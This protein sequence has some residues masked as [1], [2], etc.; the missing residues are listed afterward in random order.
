MNA[1]EDTVDRPHAVWW[2]V[3]IGGLTVLAFQGF[4]DAFYGWWIAHLHALPAQ[5]V[6]MWIFVACVPIHVFEAFYCHRLARRLGLTKSAFGWGVQSF[7]L[8]YPSTRLLRRRE[9]ARKAEAHV[10]AEAR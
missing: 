3:V 4:S 1:P 7:F 8:G 6:M 2:V 10:P 9:K 5:K